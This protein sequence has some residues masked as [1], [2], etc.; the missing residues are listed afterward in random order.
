M[1]KKISRG[2]KKYPLQKIIQ[3]TLVGCLVA[4][5]GT[6]GLFLF[7]AKDLPRP[8]KFTELSFAQSTKIFDRTGE[9]LLYEIYGEEK[10][11]NIPLDKVSPLLREAIISVED[12]DFYHHHGIDPKGILRSLLVNVRSLAPVQGASTLTQQLVRTSFLSR[13]KTVERKVKELILTL[14]LERRYS[15]DQILEFYLNQ[16]P[17]GS[18]AYGVSEGSKLFFGK[19]ASD[20]SLEESAAM[21]ALIKA[22]SF[23]SPFGPHRTDLLDRKDYVLDR[24]EENG[25]LTK[26]ERDAAKNK[27]ITFMDPSENIAA[28]HFSLGAVAELSETYG[29]DF[30][31]ENGLRVKTTLDWELQQAAEKAVKEFAEANIAYGAHNAALVA[32]DPR[33]GEVLAMVG[34]K[35]WFGDSEPEGCTS[36]STC[37]FD[38]KLNIATASPGRQPGSAFKPFV[39][40]TAFAKGSTEDTVVVDELTNFGMWGDE[41]YSPQNYDGKFRGPV[42]LRQALAQSLNVPAVKVL[43]DLA[44]LPDSISTAQAMGI[45][46]LDKGPSFYGLSLVLGGGEVKLLD[47]VS[48]YGVFANEGKRVPSFDILEV[49]DSKDNVL[50]SRK[51]TPITV[52]PAEAVSQITDILSDNDARAPVFGARSPLYFPNERVSVKTGTT[53]DYKDGWI[54]GYTKNIVAGVWVG[55]NDGTLMK[56]EPGV[57]VAGPMWHQFMDTAIQYLKARTEPKPETPTP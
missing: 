26:E 18:N 29:E 56:K 46:T 22:P 6:A 10:R 2:G 15:K 48:A 40:V 35:N 51:K 45:T 21:A 4:F 47:M 8:E 20:L 36:G 57:V 33:T 12:A 50:E 41:T 52:L 13:T 9:H 43:N 23:Y 38:P 30:L 14:E 32:I 25:Y 1:V 11:E 28:P 42:T 55:N 44:G 19:V 5:V 7:Y 31:R 54:I 34:S 24:M 3:V 53:Q 17:L 37:A 16:V 49:R 39:Y 27:E